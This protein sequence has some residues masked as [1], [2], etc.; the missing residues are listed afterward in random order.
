AATT[1]SITAEDVIMDEGRR[2]S[3][4]MPAS[5]SER[6]AQGDGAE[7]ADLEL[8]REDPGGRRRRIEALRERAVQRHGNLVVPYGEFSE[9][10]RVGRT[11]RRSDQLAI[12][13]DRHSAFHP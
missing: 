7:N 2:S 13:F 6:T 5:P 10:E 4:L 8:G 11:E 12:H 9:L 3:R 1:S